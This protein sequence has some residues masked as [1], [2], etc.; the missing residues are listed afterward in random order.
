LWADAVLFLVVLFVAVEIG[1]RFGLRL[2][3]AESPAERRTRGDV[4]LG[5]VLAL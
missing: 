1:F 4:T 3:H 2:H 5:S